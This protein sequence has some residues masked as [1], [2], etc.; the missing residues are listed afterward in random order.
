MP[1]VWAHKVTAGPWVSF[2]SSSHAA[3]MCLVMWDGR[4]RDD[5]LVDIFPGFVIY[6]KKGPL[7]EEEWRTSDGGEGD[8]SKDEYLFWSMSVRRFL[9][10]G[11]MEKRRQPRRHSATRGGDPEEI[12]G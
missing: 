12:C 5:F 7:E 8:R 6:F 1:S 10:D 4:R 3:G 11:E 2:P 9:F